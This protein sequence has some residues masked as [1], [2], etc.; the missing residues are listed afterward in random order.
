[1]EVGSRQQATGKRQQGK[2][3]T[4]GNRG[5]AKPK[6]TA[7]S[8]LPLILGTPGFRLATRTITPTHKKPL[9]V[10]DPDSRRQNG[11]INADQR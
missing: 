11:S 9:C 7:K 2:G 10:G 1:V 8:F 5:K 6:A 3:K 4:K